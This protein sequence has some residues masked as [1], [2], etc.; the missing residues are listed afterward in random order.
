MD[1]LRAQAPGKAPWARCLLRREGT[2]FYAEIK[3]DYA[4]DEEVRQ[5]R[6]IIFNEML[7]AVKQLQG[8][9]S[10]EQSKK[11]WLLK[12]GVTA[13]KDFIASLRALEFTFSEPEVHMFLHKRRIE[14]SVLSHA[15]NSFDEEAEL[16]NL[17]CGGILDE[18]E[19]R[20]GIVESAEALQIELPESHGDSISPQPQRN[21]TQ[22]RPDSTGLCPGLSVKICGLTSHP[23]LNGSF[24][25]LDKRDDQC[26]QSPARWLVTV[27]GQQYSLAEDKLQ[28]DPIPAVQGVDGAA[29]S[30]P[31]H[32]TGSD[33]LVE[34][35]SQ[36]ERSHQ[37]G[38][39]GHP[40]MK[41]L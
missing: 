20:E 21:E 5:R 22:L 6:R 8:G 25:T 2:F 3:T 37:D 12:G 19:K 26:E 14:D 40:N 35:P 31:N 9:V 36:S 24:G 1:V 16:D 11:N 28:A 29:A 30:T 23:E 15:L 41:S 27:N 34:T 4:Q 33:Q 18:I 32:F 39:S 17:L 10:F 38:K 13:A 7:Q